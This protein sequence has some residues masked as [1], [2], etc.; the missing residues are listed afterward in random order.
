MHEGLLRSVFVASGRYYYTL[1]T[2][3]LPLAVFDVHF[4]VDVVLLAEA[5]LEPPPK[6]DGGHAD[7]AVALG[8]RLA[9]LWVAA[10]AARDVGAR[11]ARRGALLRA[12]VERDAVRVDERAARHVV[13][14]AV[15]RARPPARQLHRRL[16]LAAPRERRRA[17][18]LAARQ[19][20]EDRFQHRLE[21]WVHLERDNLGVRL[22]GDR[23]DI[24][25]KPL[26]RLAV[27]GSEVD[28]GAAR[29]AVGGACE[30]PPCHFPAWTVS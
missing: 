26:Q 2:P 8:L 19:P 6:I 5:R 24:L 30:N 17:L 1:P 20:R 28:E 15:L 22:F 14:D 13:E 25:L 11:R 10:A 9:R 4:D 23:G 16:H 18:Q 7:D 12:A 3:Y 27:V 29:A 21:R